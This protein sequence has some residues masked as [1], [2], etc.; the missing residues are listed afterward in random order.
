MEWTAGAGIWIITIAVVCIAAF[1]AVFF[2]PAHPS[3]HR[4]QQLHGDP[5]DAADDASGWLIG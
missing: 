2:M 1:E 3:N 4:V 5:K